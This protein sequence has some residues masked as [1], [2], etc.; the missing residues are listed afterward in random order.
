MAVS[1]SNG[2]N[3]RDTMMSDDESRTDSDEIRRDIDRTRAEMDSTIDE[4]G[5][6]LQPQNL[7]DEIVASVKSSLFS[8]SS[9]STRSSV[10][11]R[12]LADQAGETAS[13]VGRSLIE[14]VREH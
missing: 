6:R 7:F 5:Q 9:H 1:Q 12:E 10:N 11:S 4:L 2:L 8:G 14:G 3:R 13:R